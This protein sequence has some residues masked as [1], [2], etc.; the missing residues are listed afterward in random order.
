[1]KSRNVKVWNK[2]TFDHEEMFKGSL[3]KIPAGAYILMDRHEAVE[4]KSQ[5]KQPVF[6]KGGVPDKQHLKMIVLE[7]IDDTIKEEEKSNDSFVCQKCNFEAGSH[8][9]LKSHIRSKHLQS[10]EDADAREELI[11]EG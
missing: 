5:F 2:N 4:F 9:G 1:M 7:P 8:A 10:M 6:L 3:I 11:S